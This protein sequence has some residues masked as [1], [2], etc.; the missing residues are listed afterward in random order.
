MYLANEEW[1]TFACELPNDQVNI[2]STKSTE[3]YYYSM[4]NLGNLLFR[5]GMGVHMVHNPLFKQHV[6]EDEGMPWYQQP[7]GS[8]MFMQ[9]KMKQF[10]KRTG[11]DKTG[12]QYP[13]K[14]SYPIYLEFASGDPSFL[15]MPDPMDFNTL[16]WDP[17]KMDQTM[18]PGAWGQSLMKQV[19]WARD[20]FTNN[21]EIDGI[22]Y[23]GNTKDDGGNGFRGAA[24]IA[25][26]ITKSVA[27]KS[28]MAY[29]SRTQTLG[30]VDPATYDP[31]DGPIYYPHEYKVEFGPM[32][33]GMPPKPMKFTVSDRRS[34]L[35]DVASLLWGESEFY[36]LTDPMVKDEFD[37]LFGDPMWDPSASDA[38]LKE[39]FAA[40][41]TIFPGK[42][43]MLSKGLTAVN[44]KNMMALHFRDDVGT[45]VDEWSPTFNKGNRITTANAGMAMIAL[46][47]TYH[48]LHDVAMIRNGAKMLL[49][50][51]ADFLLKQQ[52]KDGSF[53]NGYT[54]RKAEIFPSYGAKNLET[55]SFAIR[56]L[57]VAYHATKDKR[58]LTAAL[59]TYDFMEANL[60]S[61][62]A[63]VYRAHV[64][65]TNSTYG[66]LNTGATIGALRE[67]AIINQTDNIRSSRTFVNRLDSFFDNV[68][69]KGGMQ[70]AEMPQT[71]EMMPPPEKRMEMMTMMQ[72]MM[73][74]D[75]EKA[76]MMKKKMGDSDN[77]G[78]PKP[79]FV[80]GTMHGAAPVS[81]RSVTIETK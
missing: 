37:G 7:N 57:L 43:H 60:W 34:D 70:I 41:K 10:V 64:E 21:K 11:V 6:D 45:L 40:G 30:G 48:R 44:F 52:D 29:N 63:G 35:F 50:A 79:P 67:L 39:M 66:G 72:E 26:A 61:P 54:V 33:E 69:K 78:V 42:P 80:D 56:G 19:L 16:R 3:L 28:E 8:M 14:G 49:S 20:F 58:Y 13:P 62:S 5:S 24:L 55:Q 4:Y 59:K 22:T 53:A 31:A 38:D 2:G 12:D 17:A 76:M 15:T 36:F 77:D 46:A 25:Q 81:A 27:L 74:T 23:F 65:A 68:V 32:M 75:P 47:N 9:H 71:G 73:K 51:Q 18:N 1:L